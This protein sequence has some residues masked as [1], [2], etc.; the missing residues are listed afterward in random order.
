MKQ[1]LKDIYQK[2]NITPNLAQHMLMV[3]ALGEHLAE[4]WTSPDIDKEVLIDTLLLHDIGN[5]VKFDLN[6]NR[7][8]KMLNKTASPIANKQPLQHWQKKQ[9]EMI[10]KYGANA[11]QAN[12][13]II[14]ELKTNPKIKQLLENHSFEELE[15]SLQTHNWEKKLVFYCDLR[16]TPSGLASVEER[17]SDLRQRY[18]QKDEKWNNND[19]YNQWLSNSLALEKQLN[20]H[21]TLDL[22][23]IKQTDFNN[24]VIRLADRQIEV[25]V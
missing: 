7:S 9:Q 14:I 1:P 8:Q 2:Y 6:S 16:F 20:Q 19:L 4:N 17:I 25:E 10:N 24:L 22:R 18:Q 3:A 15:H 12:L 13:A 5:L 21:T 23:K 11:D